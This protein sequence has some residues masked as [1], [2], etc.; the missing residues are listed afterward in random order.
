MSGEVVNLRTARKAR[1]KAAATA[2]AAANRAR[3]GRTKAERLAQAR[4]ADR[5]AGAIDGAK[6]E[7]RG[8]DALA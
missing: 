7:G 6:R 8:E 2:E 3:F 5:L 4:E 1:A